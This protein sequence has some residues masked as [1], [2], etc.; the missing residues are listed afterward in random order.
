MCSLSL[1]WV[2][3]VLTLKRVGKIVASHSAID[4]W[5]GRQNA[6]FAVC[7]WVE[8]LN[9][10]YETCDCRGSELEVFL[11]SLEYSF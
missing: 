1:S 3:M 7:V 6:V 11:C 8:C 2:R 10:R 9:S 5:S 4:F